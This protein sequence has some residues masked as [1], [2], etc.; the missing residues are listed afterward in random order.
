MD[1][2]K[3]KF[4]EVLTSVLPITAIVLVLHFTICPI[5]SSLMYAFLLG[6]VLIII[7]LTIFLFGIDQGLEPIGHD[8]GGAL[9]HLKSYSVVI[10]ICLSRFFHFCRA[11]SPHSCPPG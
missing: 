2:L 4:K 1:A 5:D 3:T 7:G 6:S 10:T 9:I 11:R 8:I